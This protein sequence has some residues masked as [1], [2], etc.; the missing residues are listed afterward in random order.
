MSFLNILARKSSTAGA[1]GSM[2]IYGQ[3]AT[4]SSSPRW[5]SWV[6]YSVIQ[7][8][9][10]AIAPRQTVAG[11]VSSAIGARQS[12]GKPD[13]MAPK[14][15]LTP[16]RLAKRTTNETGPKLS[17]AGPGPRPAGEPAGHPHQVRVVQQLI[18]VT[19]QP[20]PPHPEP[21][22][23]VPQR[24]IRV[25]HNP[26]HTIVGIGQQIPVAFNELINHRG[27]LGDTSRATI[28]RQPKLPRRD[29][30]YRAKSGTGVDVFEH[31]DFL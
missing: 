4:T 29:H 24:E 18:T 2:P 10:L 31:S 11:G 21:T 9:D 13:S 15:R 22:R 28:T 27:T 16:M 25:E 14:P 7:L 23:V 1:L 26:I 5:R 12:P 3:A 6:S 20:P 8:H 30:R 17:W 19:V